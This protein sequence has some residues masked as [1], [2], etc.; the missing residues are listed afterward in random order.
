MLRCVSL[1]CTIF[2]SVDAILNGFLSTLALGQSLAWVPSL[3][4]GFGVKGSRICQMIEALLGKVAL[5]WYLGFAIV[6]I[7]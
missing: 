1:V 2:F 4:F 5:K 7:G 6:M 3:T